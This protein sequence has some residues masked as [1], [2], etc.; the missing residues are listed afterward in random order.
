[1][2]IY[3]FLVIDLK[4][5]LENSANG[6]PQASLW[7]WI[8]Y[9]VLFCME[10]CSSLPAPKNTLPCQKVSMWTFL[11]TCKRQMTCVAFPPARRRASLSSCVSGYLP[12]YLIATRGLILWLGL[13]SIKVNYSLGSPHSESSFLP[14]KLS[15]PYL[16]LSVHEQRPSHTLTLYM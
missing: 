11:F 8:T 15:N 13:S 2:A 16:T 6:K 7:T 9:S 4:T 10:T 3:H 14:R 12:A 5:E 1:M